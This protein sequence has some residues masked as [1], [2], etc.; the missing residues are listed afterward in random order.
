MEPAEWIVGTVA[1]TRLLKPAFDGCWALYTAFSKAERFP[2]DFLITKHLL[3]CQYV[4]FY[5][6][7][8]TRVSELEYGLDD[9]DSSGQPR[10]NAILGLLENAQMISIEC[11]KLVQEVENSEFRTECSVN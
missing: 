7:G 3:D 2:V 10:D 11:E 8:K 6:L 4:K 5:Q 1:A 9:P